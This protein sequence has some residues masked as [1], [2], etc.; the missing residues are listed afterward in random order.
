MADT[1]KVEE[2]IMIAR[3]IDDV[4][5]YMSDPD[6]AASWTNNLVEYSVDGE[7]DELGTV[8]SYVV[9]VAGLRLQGT[10]EL[11][12]YEKDKSR[13]YRSKDSKIGYER[14]LEFAVD[15]VHTRVTWRQEAEAGTG[16]FKFADSIV[17]KLY[18]RDVRGNLENVK[19]ILEA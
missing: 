18:A 11:T 9:K 16:L 3:P 4:F 5:E 7:P 17:Q 12:G 10:E 13:T 1:L 8:T 2:S 6:N 14:T 15:G 19:T